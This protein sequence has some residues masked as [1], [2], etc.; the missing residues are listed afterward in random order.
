MSE[1]DTRRTYVFEGTRSK[2]CIDPRAA[3]V[4]AQQQLL[5]ESAKKGFN[6][7]LLERCVSLV[8]DSLWFCDPLSHLLLMQLA[9]D[10]ISKG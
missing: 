7:L 4:F 1:A 8:N 5:K 10:F 2:R 3:V 9:A 6:V